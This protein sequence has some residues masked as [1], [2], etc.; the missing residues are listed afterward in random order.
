MLK[1]FLIFCLLLPLAGCAE[2]PIKDGELYLNANTSATV[3]D[4]AVGRIK[5]KF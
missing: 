4:G 5:N 3:E 1:V 2:V